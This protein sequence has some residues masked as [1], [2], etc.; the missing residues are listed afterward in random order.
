MSRVRF[1]TTWQTAYWHGRTLARGQGSDSNL[2]DVDT[3]E[4]FWI[5]GPKRDETDG[6]YSNALAGVDEDTR[7]AYEAFLNSAPLPGREHR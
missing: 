4:E 7:E 2:Y 5:S 6:R 1:S 3:Q